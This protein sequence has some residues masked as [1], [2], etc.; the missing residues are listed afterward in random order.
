MAPDCTVV[1]VDS[2]DPDSSL[3]ITFEISSAALGVHGELDCNSAM[4]LLASARSFFSECSA[5]APVTLSLLGVT[6]IDSAG[7]SAVADVA[8]AAADAGRELVLLPPD[9][10]VARVFALAGEGELLRTTTDRPAAR[11]RSRPDNAAQGT[12]TAFSQPAPRRSNCS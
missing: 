3:L 11:R 7:V 6:F 10:R 8:A 2:P 5:G 1:S 4:F 9:G 12:T